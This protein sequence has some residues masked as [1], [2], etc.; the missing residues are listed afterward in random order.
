MRIGAGGI[1]KALKFI[2]SLKADRWQIVAGQEMTD[3][4][5]KIF[6]SRLRI[7]DQRSFSLQ[8]KK[9]SYP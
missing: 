6:F 3:S 2:T 7:L 9:P 4:E 1:H 5:E 8:K